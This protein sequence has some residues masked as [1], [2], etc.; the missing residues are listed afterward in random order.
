MP[1]GPQ[2][3]LVLAITEAPEGIIQI[4]AFSAPEIPFVGFLPRAVYTFPLLKFDIDVWLFSLEDSSEGRSDQSIYGGEVC[5]L[6]DD[7]ASG[8]FSFE[9]RSQ[10]CEM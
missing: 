5:E 6:H 2:R 4:L 1:P 3:V 9:C 10:S 8:S 7:I